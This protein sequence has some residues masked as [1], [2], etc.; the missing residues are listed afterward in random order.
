MNICLEAVEH[1][2]G[3]PSD[4]A[5]PRPVVQVEHWALNAGD[6]LLL[7]GVSGSGKTTLL[8]I[9]AGLLRPSAGKVYYDGYDLYAATE[10]N[11]DHFRAREIGYVF[12]NHHLLGA[13]TALEN[14]TLP[15]AFAG[16]G[17]GKA[18]RARAAELLDAVGLGGLL[19]RLPRQLS[20]GQR[21]RVAVA[22]ALV[23]NPHV[24]LADEPT[25][26]LD[27]AAAAQVMNLLQA[28]C[29]Q[30]DAILIVASHDP[31]LFARFAKTMDLRSGTLHSGE[32]T[33]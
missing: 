27:E 32:P 7:R 8:N 5:N 22:R 12:Q 28:V 30:N 1:R 10:T 26:A 29:R 3:S 15:Q 25:A 19:H 24:L 13:L 4:E 33:S 20:T 31:A 23:N 11:R 21:L 9:V 16:F 2:Y 18:Q 17:Q 6:Q 14:V